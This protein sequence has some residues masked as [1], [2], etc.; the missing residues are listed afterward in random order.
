MPPRMWRMWRAPWWRPGQSADAYLARYALAVGP[1]GLSAGR[2]MLA[3]VPPHM[4]LTAAAML[5]ETLGLSAVQYAARCAAQADFQRKLYTGTDVLRLPQGVHSSLLPC[6]PRMRVLCVDG[7]AAARVPVLLQDLPQLL[8]ASAGTLQE[9]QLVN[10]VPSQELLSALARMPQLEVLSTDWWHEWQAI[11]RL[12]ASISGL[13]THGSAAS[14]SH[15]LVPAMHRAALPASVHTLRFVP[16]RRLA[17]MNARSG[18]PAAA[19]APPQAARGDVGRG[20]D[21]AQL[22]HDVTSAAPGL[23]VI[24]V[25]AGTDAAQAL[26]AEREH[27]AAA[28]GRMVVL[29]RMP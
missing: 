12:P 4:H 8:A 3:L 15:E 9:L 1:R 6:L 29:R 21:G 2:L 10:V 16:R 28:D 20:N 14:A 19:A 5:K 24:E 7:S 18:S 25:E 27:V 23:R 11:V 17:A 13:A 22:L 26:E